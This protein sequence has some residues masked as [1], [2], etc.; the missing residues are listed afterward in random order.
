M[1][2]LTLVHN[3][4]EQAEKAFIDIEL[5]LQRFETYWHAWQDS[6]LHRFN[7]SLNRQPSVSIPDSLSE[8]INLSRHYQQTSQELFNPAIGKLIAAYGF[9]GKASPNQSLINEIIRDIP[10][11]QDLVIKGRQASSRNP[12]LQ[13][14]FGGIAKGYAMA[15]I[16]V[17]LKN[18]GFDHFLINAGGD[19]LTSG[20][21]INQPWLVAIQNPFAPG[22]IASIEL[23]GDQS[24]FTSGN[25]QRYYLQ[26]DKIV[27]HII[28]PRSGRPSDNIS[29]A[30]V[31]TVDAT[32]AD[33]AATTLMIDGWRNHR[34]LSKSLG[35]TDYLI[36]DQSGQIIVSSTMSSKIQYL[37]DSDRFHID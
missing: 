4:P 30:T 26:D 37:V 36:V 28:D 1:I 8:L 16:A 19:V 27:H 11:M 14:D 10:T 2:D 12:H 3:N 13:L 24:L 6:D 18:A 32:L 5:K 20:R 17:D 31:L 15:E 25:Y 7:Q 21:R 23:S 34:S 29:S 9:H 35:V 33:V 22:A